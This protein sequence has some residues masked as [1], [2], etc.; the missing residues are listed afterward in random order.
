MDDTI[1]VE[2]PEC[3]A[4]QQISPEFENRRGRCK[5]GEVFVLTPVIRTTKRKPIPRVAEPNV[6]VVKGKLKPDVPTGKYCSTCGEAIHI[7]AEI[8]PH[9]GVR[10]SRPS[11]QS[12]DITTSQ[13]LS[14]SSRQLLPAVLLCVFVGIV[15]A[16][17]FYCGHFKTG[18][19]YIVCF[20][21]GFALCGVTW[22]VV[23]VLW[24]IDFIYLVTGK[25]KDADGNLIT[26]WVL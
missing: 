13:G 1:E 5:C 17:S 16:H 11:T 18:I 22:L 4:R 3:G 26:Q 20:L 15:G 19:V 14:N 9:C 2:C 23:L 12:N 7:R 25:Y 21:L 10:Q 6:L 24:V 8:C